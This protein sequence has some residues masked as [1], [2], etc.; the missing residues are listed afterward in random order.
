MDSNNSAGV[1]TVN[2]VFYM[3]N[4]AGYDS[5]GN[6]TVP[7]SDIFHMAIN[8]G[9]GIAGN[10]TAPAVSALDC[11]GLISISLFEWRMNNVNC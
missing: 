4:N 11:I 8:I 3:Q 7:A 2:G 5:L 10:V 6:I 1:P 9:Y